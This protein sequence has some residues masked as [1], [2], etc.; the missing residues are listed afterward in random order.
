LVWPEIG[1]RRLGSYLV[2]RLVR[3]P[4]T[5]HTIA[6]GIACGTAISFT[7]FIGFHI[8]LGALLALVVRGNFLAMVVGTL[9][10]NPWTFP[11]IWLASYELGRFILGIGPGVPS[12]EPFSFHRVVRDL[13]SVIWP[14]T[15][16]G[17]PLGLIAGLVIY[18]PTVRL[19][20]AYQ[21]ARRRRRARRATR[22][23]GAPLEPAGAP[24]DAAGL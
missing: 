6:A 10:G 22:G 21:E 13:E 9:V 15:V 8:L 20:S 7:P 18:F 12:L 16:G 24:T 14:M 23:R 5:P 2:K 11:F 3:L 17:T 19:V 1:W 4:G